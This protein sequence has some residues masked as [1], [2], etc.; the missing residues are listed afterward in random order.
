LAGQRY[1]AIYSRSLWPIDQ[2]DMADSASRQFIRQV[3][4]NYEDFTE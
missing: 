1:A 4:E 2:A 3:F